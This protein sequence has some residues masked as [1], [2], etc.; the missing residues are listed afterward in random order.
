LNP[1]TGKTAPAD[2]GRVIVLGALFVPLA[3]ANL[4]MSSISLVDQALLLL[5]SAYAVLFTRISAA[6]GEISSGYVQSGEGA[7]A[8][9]ALLVMTTFLSLPGAVI[10]A[11]CVCIMIG[12]EFYMHMVGRTAGKGGA[13]GGIFINLGAVAAGWYIVTR[14]GTSGALLERVLTGFSRTAVGGAWEAFFFLAVFILL[15]AFQMAALPQLKLYSQGKGY[16]EITGFRFG[17]ARFSFIAARGFVV[18]GIVLFAGCLAGVGFLA[19]AFREKNLL[20][21]EIK[22]VLVVNIFLQV[23]VLLGTVAGGAVVAGVAV[24]LSY[25]LMY[26][27]RRKNPHG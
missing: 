3:A 27:Y 26:L 14:T 20:A 5:G 4:T 12:F 11:L 21:D 7:V 17:R 16:F 15:Y 1:V 6:D 25:L 18:T 9:L 13:W 19:G 10:A 22:S 2:F 23:L 8:M 24:A